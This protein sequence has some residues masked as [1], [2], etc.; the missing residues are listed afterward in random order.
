MGKIFSEN[1]YKYAKGGGIRDKWKQPAVPA[2]SL[3]EFFMKA[4]LRVWNHLQYPPQ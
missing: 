1:P 4:H 3:C 2:V